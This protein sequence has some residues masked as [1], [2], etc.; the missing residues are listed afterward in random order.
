MKF[1]TESVITSEGFPRFVTDGFLQTADEAA[2]VVITRVPGSATTQLIEERHELKGFKIKAKSCD[3][4]PMAGFVCEL[5]AFNKA[6]ASK[7]AFNARENERYEQT[8]IATARAKGPPYLPL[9]ISD[10]AKD[11]VLADK[12]AHYKVFDNDHVVGWV[13][14]R[15]RSVQAE[16]LL[17]RVTPEAGSGWLVYHSDVLINPTRVLQQFRSYD[18]Q[19]EWYSPRA[20]RWPG[21]DVPVDEIAKPQA[22]KD[23]LGKYRQHLKKR[24][25]IT[26]KPSSDQP[27]RP[28]H[29]IRNPHPSYTGDLAYKNAV[30]GDYDLFA[31][32]PLAASGSS[33]TAELRRY[34]EREPAEISA[35]QHGLRARSVCHVEPAKKL[36]ISMDRGLTDG[37]ILVDIVPGYEEIK[38][39]EDGDV[40]NWS[41]L[42]LLVAG[43]LNSAV[44]LRHEEAVE[45]AATAD[46]KAA[47]SPK[48]DSDA[49]QSPPN[50]AFHSDEGGRPAVYELDLPV[51]AFLPSPFVTAAWLRRPRLSHDQD[52]SIEWSEPT[53][54]WSQ[55][56]R[57]ILIENV[58][59][60]VELIEYLMPYVTVV[61]NHGWLAH[62]LAL[63]HEPVSPADVAAMKDDAKAFFANRQNEIESLNPETVT[64]LRTRL[65]HLLLP[66]PP[67]NVDQIV[68][69]DE[70]TGK[71]ESTRRAEATARHLARA[72]QQERLFTKLI[73]EVHLVTRAALG[74][75]KA[76]I[77]DHPVPLA[78]D[79]VQR[80]LA[81][82]DDPKP[83]STDSGT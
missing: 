34:I 23:W 42:V 45:K 68:G 79:V 82:V 47:K 33:T 17:V 55:G 16:V 22:W 80:L 28:I 53:P 1:R 35:A 8:L 2:S 20:R 58:P 56:Q 4:G 13:W 63:F 61:L 54:P 15:K 57:I 46:S 73:E 26:L 74:E 66:V 83:P 5:P 51:V 64:D 30:S 78:D 21:V 36:A 52:G 40:G 6:G 49:K 60:F 9:R 72:L 27:F 67:L 19:R 75:T 76:R 32:W 50:V 25:S 71:A 24:M 29:G 69:R 11:I 65:R 59:D 37:K 31:V 62:L 77:A 18:Y 44:A 3:W 48:A 14:D 43:L 41:S 38:P 12:R 70:K 7:I 81:I 10:E 39:L